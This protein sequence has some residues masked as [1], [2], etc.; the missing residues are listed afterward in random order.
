MRRF[1]VVRHTSLAFALLIV[2][3]LVGCQRASSPEAARTAP[4]TPRELHVLAW[5]G[6]DEDDFLGPLQQE[7]GV[8]IKVKTYVGGDQMYSLFLAAPPGTYDVVV[9]DAEYGRK[10]FTEHQLRA[11]PFDLWS[12]P[13]LFAQFAQGEPVRQDSDVYGSVVRWGALGMV[14]NTKYVT[15]A[16]AED[17]ATLLRPQLAGRVGIFDRYLPTMGVL[18]RYL[19]HSNPYDLSQ[20]ELTDLRGLLA[21]LHKQVG[22][23]HANTGEV[24]ADLRDE[25]VYVTP[26]IGEWAAAVLSEE[27]KPIDWVVPRQGGVMWVE[28]LAI[29]TSAVQV[30]LSEKYIEMVRRPEHLAQLAWRKA[31]HSQVSKTTAYRYLA[32]KQSELLKAEDVQTLTALMDRLAMRQLPG[33]RTSESDWV[34]VWG[35]FKAGQSHP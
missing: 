19:G 26:G 12:S 27:G 14:Y 17:Y 33:P 22:S 8:P 9:V 28:A 10:L 5:V 30:D 23:V 2:G 32:P 35:E 20:A 21:K 15:K 11:L 16:Q 34:K 31:Y 3:V 7:L 4:P 6:Y 1:K 18:S 25:S 13:D 24:I 29:P